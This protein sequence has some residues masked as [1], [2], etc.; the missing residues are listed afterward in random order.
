[1][2]ERG[3]ENSL[4]ARKVG[5]PATPSAITAPK[6]DGELVDAA[7][8]PH[9]KGFCV[10]FDAWVAEVSDAQTAN[11]DAIEARVKFVS[12]RLGGRTSASSVSWSAG[13]GRPSR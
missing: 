10:D 6:V 5:N 13:T 3:R 12:Q 8:I 2:Q 7:L 1:V 11:A 4:G 9:L